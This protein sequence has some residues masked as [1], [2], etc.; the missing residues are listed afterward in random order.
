MALPLIGPIVS[1][2]SSVAT[3]FMDER[4][5]KTEHK[6]KIA[7]AKVDAEIKRLQ[8]HADAEVNYDI[9]ALK[10]QQYSWKDEYAL[11]VITLPFLGSFIPEVQEYVLKG[12][13]YVAKAPEWYSYT[14]IGAIS[15]SLGIR[16]ATKLLKK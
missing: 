9:E 16:W 8:R 11:L 12:W 6:A 14:F 10:Q 2:V 15:A 5:V 3:S 4:K 13:E 1:A 7:E